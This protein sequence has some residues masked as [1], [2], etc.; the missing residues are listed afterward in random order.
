MSALLALWSFIA[1][2][3]GRLVATGGLALALGFAQGWSLKARLDRSATLQAV[4]AKQHI[5]IAAA[6][7]SAEAASAVVA[8][9]A[10]RDANNQEIIRDL[11]DRLAQHAPN[12]CVLDPAAAERLR[13]L[14]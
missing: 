13:R 2:P 5:D 8:D 10:Q 7:E 1:S 11:Q 14:R 4:I 9:I 6:R 12:R 3:L